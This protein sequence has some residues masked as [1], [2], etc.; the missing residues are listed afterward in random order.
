[1]EDIVETK[2]ALNLKIDKEELWWEQCA[3]VNWLRYGDQNSKFF[4]HYASSRHNFNCIKGLRDENNTLRTD[5]MAKL[6]IA[7][8]F[9]EDLFGSRGVVEVDRIYD[10]VNGK[11]SSSMNDFLLGAFK[12]EE[13]KSAIHDM[14]LTKTPRL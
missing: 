10:E 12:P 3:K 2:L 5:E 14:G 11:I 4:H 1:M 6:N 8:N 13:I 9:F 7:V